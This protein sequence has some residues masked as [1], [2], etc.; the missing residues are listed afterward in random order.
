MQDRDPYDGAGFV[1]EVGD[2]GSIG[3]LTM[4]WKCERMASRETNSSPELSSGLKSLETRLCWMQRES[5]D[6]PGSKEGGV[7]RR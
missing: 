5:K 6:C 4:E 2:K 3:K 7:R 1:S